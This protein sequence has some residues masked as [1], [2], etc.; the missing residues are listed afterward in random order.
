MF[1]FCVFSQVFVLAVGFV[2]FCKE[3]CVFF[4]AS[5]FVFFALDSVFFASVLVFFLPRVCVS[6]CFWFC[7]FSFF[8][9]VFCVV[10]H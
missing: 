9:L 8:T 3:F 10:F 2:F 7:V 4:V 5:V 1:F 6:S